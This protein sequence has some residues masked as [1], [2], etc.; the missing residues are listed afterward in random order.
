ML[1]VDRALL[2]GRPPSYVQI[3]TAAA[4]EGQERL[5]YWVELGRTHA[6]RLGVTPIPVVVRDRTQAD[7]PAVAAQIDGAGLIYLSGGDPLFLA[8]T[9][10]DTLLWRAI[11]AAWRGGAALAGCSAG[12]MALGGWVPD[13]RHPTRRGA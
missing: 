5:T 1:A 12:A 8:D 7:D 9:L 2:D 13:V 11:D 4:R 6:A 3:P 10:R